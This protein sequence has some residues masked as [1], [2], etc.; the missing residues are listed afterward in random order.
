MLTPKAFDAQG[1]ASN[2]LVRLC[3]RRTTALGRFL[4][5]N[6]TS[7]GSPLI[8]LTTVNTLTPL[9]GISPYIANTIGIGLGAAWNWPSNSRVIWPR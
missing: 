8:S 1:R 2:R 3:Q 7:V 9:L 5:F 4:K 6:C